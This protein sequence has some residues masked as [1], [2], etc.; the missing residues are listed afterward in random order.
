MIFE[1]H[2]LLFSI[3]VGALAQGF[4]R[5]TDLTRSARS[6]VLARNGMVAT[7][8]PLATQAGLDVLRR[9]GNAFDAAVAAAA[10]LNVVEPMSTGIGGDAFVLAWSAKEKKLLGLNGSGRSSARA[11]I[12]HYRAKGYSRFPT[13]GPDSV[14]VP[15]A[16]DAWAALVARCG[17]LPIAE[18]LRDAIRY[19][20]E[21]FPVSEIIASGWSGAESLASI[22]EFAAAYLVRD[23]DG[24][25]APRVGEVFRQPDLA[26]TLKKVASGGRDI[27]YRG[28]IAE[29]IAAYLKEKGSL[30]GLD[31]LA[32]HASEW[33]EPVGVDFRGHEVFELPPNGQGIVALEMLRILDGYDLKSLGHNSAEYLHLFLEA[34]KFAF[35][36]R[37]RFIAD[38]VLQKVPVETLLSKEYAARVRAKIEPARASKRPRSVLEGASDTVYLAAADGEG[39]MVSFINSLFHGFGSRLVVPG[40]GICLQNRGALFSLDGDHPNRVEP[41]K[42]PFHTIIPGMVLKGGRPYLVFGVMGGDFQPQGHVQVLLN[43]IVFGMN[44]Q[45]A[46]ERARASEGGGVVHLEAAIGSDVREKLR[47]MGHDVRPGGAGGFGGYQGILLDPAMGVLMAGSDNRK[48]GCAAG[49]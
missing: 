12:E 17:K 29:K 44:P 15:G 32:A 11:T 3:G 49:Y 21:G 22:P 14:T 43:H 30:I 10:V 24:R 9:G 27:F 4:D 47:A 8:Q 41:R 40:T 45:E 19:A 1:S 35:A 38:P 34:K 28:E 42:R 25:R 46:G 7:S 20:E 36:D 13:F 23:G 48:D 37:D 2:F 16:C 18:V 26:A 33:V 31:D 39:N 6:M 5:P